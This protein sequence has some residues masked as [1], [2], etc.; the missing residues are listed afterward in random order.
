MHFDYLHE[1]VPDPFDRVANVKIGPEL[2]TPV[3][4]LIA[5][6]LFVMTACVMEHHRWNEARAV[7]R[8]AAVRVQESR[9]AL[10]RTSLARVE[11]DRLLALDRRLRAIHLSGS[12]LVARLIDVADHL[13]RNVWLT[14][15][16][17]RDKAVDI[18]G[19]ADGVKAL[20]DA[21]GGLMNGSTVQSPSLVSAGKDD[22]SHLMSFEM[23][24][25]DRLP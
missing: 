21:V 14:S 25:E 13:P 16:A 5:A 12:V 11:V 18:A 22:R 24:V 6:L 10:N 2:R 4:V 1:S 7:E 19:K 15:I 17:R 20:G 9:A 3:R 8:N 23:R